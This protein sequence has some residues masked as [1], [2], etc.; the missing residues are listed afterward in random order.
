MNPKTDHPEQRTDFKH[1][2]LEQDII[3]C[4]GPILYRILLWAK[5]WVCAG[6]PPGKIRLGSYEAWAEMIG[7]MLEFAGI[8]GF[9]TNR[10]VLFTEKNQQGSDW[11]TFYAAWRERFKSN[12]VSV[13]DLYE[14]I[15]GT[16]KI[17]GDEAFEET[18]PTQLASAFSRH[19]DPLN[20][21]KTLGTILHYKLETRYG[22]YY[23]VKEPNPSSSHTHINRYAVW[24][25]VEPNIPQTTRE[26]IEEETREILRRAHKSR[27]SQ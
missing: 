25:D 19:A 16:E 6:R 11:Q 18:L 1:P 9:L 3:D 14:K 2:K 17:K 10:D 15:K 20:I 13:W 23:L 5:A 12:Y 4:R 22:P 27:N 21:R 26:Q 24:S 8:E 7:G